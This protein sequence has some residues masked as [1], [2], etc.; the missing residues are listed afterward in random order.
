M[1]EC[2]AQSPNNLPLQSNGLAKSI[3][4]TSHQQ[5]SPLDAS[6]LIAKGCTRAIDL[7]EYQTANNSYWSFLTFSWA[8]IASIDIE[9]EVLRFAG[10]LRF[11]LWAVYS[12]LRL[13][14]YKAKLSY[15]PP[16]KDDK[17]EDPT[18]PSLADNL[19]TSKWVSEEDDFLLLWASHVSDA[20]ESTYHCPSSKLDD[21]VFQILVIRY[22]R[23]VLFTL[24]PAHT[25]PNSL[26]LNDLRL[27][28]KKN[29]SRLDVVKMMLGLGDGKHADH[30]GAEFI[31]CTAYR[32][33]PTVPSINDLDGEVVEEGPVQGKVKPSAMKVFCR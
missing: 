9:S 19:D 26:R 32:L 30:P 12:I 16:T 14:S 24:Q 23:T 29:V 6:F 15:L 21:G 3:A 8:M 18:L 13:K 25:T 27:C 4:R 22:D 31:A 10:A 11:D 17:K 20:A 33:E 28:R 2:Y 1:I 5:S 7:S